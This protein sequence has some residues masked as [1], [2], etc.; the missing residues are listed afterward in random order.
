MPF[1]KNGLNRMNTS[2]NPHIPNVMIFE[3]PVHF[4]PHIS[5]N[6]FIIFFPH[7]PYA[8][9][10]GKCVSYLYIYIHT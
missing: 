3:L 6:N 5:V 1:F 10:V 9:Y 4:I 7:K 8:E 2:L